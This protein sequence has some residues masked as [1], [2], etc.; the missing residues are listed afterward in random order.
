MSEREKDHLKKRLELQEK[1]KKMGLAGQK[2]GKHKVPE[3]EVS[4]QIG[5]DLSES[6]RG[7]KVRLSSQADW[8]RETHRVFMTARRQFVQGSVPKSSA[9]S[10]H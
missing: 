8:P 7:L 4:V 5:E 1:M 2:L 6:L 9:A 3:G 10:S